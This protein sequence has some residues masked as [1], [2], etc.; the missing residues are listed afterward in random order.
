MVIVFGRTLIW[1]EDTDNPNIVSCYYRKNVVYANSNVSDEEIAE[2]QEDGIMMQRK[3]LQNIEALSAHSD[4]ND[5]EKLGFPQIG[6]VFILNTDIVISDEMIG[7]YGG[8]FVDYQ[9]NDSSELNADYINMPGVALKVYKQQLNELGYNVKSTRLMTLAEVNNIIKKTTKKNLP[10]REWDI[11]N[12][13]TN[14]FGNLQY[15]FLIDY[16]RA[17]DSWVYSSTYW[18][19]TAIPVDSYTSGVLFIDALGAICGS[20]ML[21]IPCTSI[22][23]TTLPAGLRPLITIPTSELQYLIQIKTDG[24]GTIQVVENALGNET[25]QFKATSKKGYKLKSIVITTDSGEIVEF[26]E[27]EIIQNEDGTY[28]IDKSK[29]TMPFENVTIEA[30]W[31]LDIMNP[32]TG[33]KLSLFILL[34]VILFVPIKKYY[35][36]KSTN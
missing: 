2:K 4:P 28:T 24:N 33:R 13:D 11:N 35:K 8:K 20:N 16:L 18:I 12:P 31:S 3:I 27:G 14:L 30:R 10:I 19:G 29:F 25:I 17:Q 34:I 7:E 23:S 36:I 22:A 6:D 32:K 26:D 21:G 15:D 5:R 1:Y 9:L